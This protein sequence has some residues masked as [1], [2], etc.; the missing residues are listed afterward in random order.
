[1]TQQAIRDWT[2]I[3]FVLIGVLMFGVVLGYSTCQI[4]HH[5]YQRLS[6]DDGSTRC[7]Q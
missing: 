3:S 1:M 7:V 5:K 6:C 4:S 2:A